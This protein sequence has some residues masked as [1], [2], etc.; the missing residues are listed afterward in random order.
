MRKIFS[1]KYPTTVASDTM[2]F[3]GVFK[4]ERFVIASPFVKNRD[5]IW[6]IPMAIQLSI[7]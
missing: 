2:D 3:I 5:S 7:K 6:I 4:N 1:L